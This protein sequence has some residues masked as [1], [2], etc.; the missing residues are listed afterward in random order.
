MERLK[1]MKAFVLSVLFVLAVINVKA[2]NFSFDEL[3]TYLDIKKDKI[4]SILKQKNFLLEKEGAFDS[5]RGTVYT[6][7]NRKKGP[8]NFINVYASKSG[9]ASLNTSIVFVTTN[10]DEQNAIKKTLIDAKFTTD[11]A[12]PLTYKNT[13]YIVNFNAL[14]VNSNYN[15]MAIIV[16][17]L[18][19]QMFIDLLRKS[20]EQN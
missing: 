12:L 6:Y 15:P 14:G 2:Q 4:D 13:K 9:E 5:G 10:V 17:D 7:H 1:Y 20:K 19:N 16:K 18:K 8:G 11:G 3:T